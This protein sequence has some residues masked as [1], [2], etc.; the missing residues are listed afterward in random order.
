MFEKLKKQDDKS[1]ESGATIG[2]LPC[3]QHTKLKV[4]FDFIRRRLTTYFHSS[5]FGDMHDYQ[6]IGSVKDNEFIETMITTL[7]ILQE[8][9]KTKKHEKYSK[10]AECLTMSEAIELIRV[11]MEADEIIIKKDRAQS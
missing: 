4:S 3:S 7:K 1:K 9:I 8:K 11:K 5:E 6:S 2:E 10:I